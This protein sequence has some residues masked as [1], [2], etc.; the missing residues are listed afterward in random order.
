MV[1]IVFQFH[2]WLDSESNWGDRVPTSRP[3][4]ATQGPFSGG[5][6]NPRS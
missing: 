6:K 2:G 5:V 3:W 1:G 4:G